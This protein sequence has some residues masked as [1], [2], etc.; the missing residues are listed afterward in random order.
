[1]NW[2][3]IKEISNESF[4]HIGNHS[5]SHGYLIDQNEEEIIKDIINQSLILKINLVIIQ[6]FFISFW[7]IWK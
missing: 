6:N 5:H 4:V 1:M 3:Q 2:E 7:R